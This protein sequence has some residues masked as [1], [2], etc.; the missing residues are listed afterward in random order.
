V[1]TTFN[2]KAVLCLLVCA[3]LGLPQH[4]FASTLYIDTS[5]TEFFVGDSVLFRVRLDSEHNNINTVEGTIA[6]EYPASAASLVDINTASSQFSLWPSKPI[7]SEENT[8]ISFVGGVP[9]G[10]VS[11][12]AIVFNF[13]LKLQEAGQIALSPNNADVY[14]NDGLGT[15]D[16][17]MMKNIVFNVLPA[18]DG[19]LSDDEWK[20]IVAEDRTPPESFDVTLGNNPALFGGQYFISFFTT[21]AA[22]GVAYYEVQEGEGEFV[23]AE[24]PFLLSDQSLSGK[25]TV[26]AFDKAGNET[27]VEYT[28]AP[29]STTFV[30]LEL[31]HMIWAAVIFFFVCAIILVMWK[32][33]S[34]KK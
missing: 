21:D 10:L 26:K 19:T 24:S 16:I 33:L 8:S 29:L 25:I 6:L 27:V 30:L 14:L 9:G 7:P 2:R 17:V 3:A 22:S 1:K 13:V 5:R 20:R 12:D 18:K 11:S 28:P 4:V 34:R 31:R 32:T 23:R 15:K